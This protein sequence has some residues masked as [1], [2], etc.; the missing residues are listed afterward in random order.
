MKEYRIK[1]KKKIRETSKKWQQNKYYTDLNYRLRNILQKRIVSVLKGYYKS[2]STLEL[3]GCSLEEFKKYL[4]SQFH[5]DPRI[6]WKTYG[7]KGWHI[8]HIIPCASFDLTKEEEQRKC[9]H[10]TNLQPLWWLD[11]IKKSDKIS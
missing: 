11:N 2:Q 7:R 6:S 3:L 9:F 5:K 8:D 10:Y 4:E 1:N